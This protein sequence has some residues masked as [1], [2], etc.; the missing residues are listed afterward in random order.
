MKL[1]RAK[2]LSLLLPFWMFAAAIPVLADGSS[3]PGG[4][5]DDDSGSGGSS[6]VRCEIKAEGRG[7]IV[8]EETGKWFSFNFKIEVKDDKTKL[9]FRAVDEDS[10][11]CITGV[12]VTNVERIDDKTVAID[13]DV[14]YGDHQEGTLRVIITDN[15]KYGP[16]SITVELPDGTSI[17]GDVGSGCYCKWGKIKLKVKCKEEK[18]D[19]GHDCKGHPECDDHPYCGQPKCKGHL[20]CDEGE[21]CDGHPECKPKKC[22]GDRSCKGHPDCKQ[23]PKCDVPNCTGHQNCKKEH[24][25]GHPECRKNYK[26]KPDCKAKYDSKKRCSCKI[27]A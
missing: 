5:Y 6:D 24:C 25:N 21:D 18:C 14:I 22:K 27:K 11:V 3:G 10:G 12:R 26:H 23:H 13:L 7:F 9:R 19:G 15:G 4:G 16:D 2:F 20:D 1:C 8:V 17:T